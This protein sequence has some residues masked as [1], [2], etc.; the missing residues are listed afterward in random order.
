[1]LSANDM[2]LMIVSLRD[3]QSC[4]TCILCETLDRNPSTHMS[5][6]KSQGAPAPQVPAPAKKPG[7]SDK[8]T[9]V[10]EHI[11]RELRAMFDDVVAEP[12]PE[13]FQKLLEEL[14][15]KQPKD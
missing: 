14:E 9:L 12:V 4:R 10:S 15:E 6:S 11:G 5:K 2:V 8:A 3:G 7:N 13:R 1:M